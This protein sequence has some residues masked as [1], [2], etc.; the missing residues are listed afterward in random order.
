MT[1]NAWVLL[2][3]VLCLQTNIAELISGTDVRVT[4]SVSFVTTVYNC[5]KQQFERKIVEMSLL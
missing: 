5:C 2:E 1:S 4:I 3:D